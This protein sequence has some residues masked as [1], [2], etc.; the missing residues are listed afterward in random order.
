MI[1]LLGQVGDAQVSATAIRIDLICEAGHHVA[2]VYAFIDA[3]KV[4]PKSIFAEFM[5]RPATI[6]NIKAKATIL[7]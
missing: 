4:Y 3:R 7:F 1:T 2:K 6:L 5:I